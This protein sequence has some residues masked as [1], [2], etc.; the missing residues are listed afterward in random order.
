MSATTAA[1]IGVGTKVKGF[2]AAARIPFLSV[3]ILPYLLGAQMARTWGGVQISAP[4]FWLGLAGVVLI[5]LATYFNGEYYDLVEDEVSTQLGRSKF[6]GGGGSVLDGALA[7]ETPRRAANVVTLLAVG[8]GLLLA[9]VYKTGI[10]TLPMG[11]FGMA[12]GYFYSARPFRWVERGIGEFMIGICYGWLPIAVGYYLQ[13]QQLPALLFWTSLP[14]GFTIFNVIY[15]NEYPDFEGDLKAGKRNLLQ[16]VGRE[17]GI[18]IY[19]AA[20]ALAVLTFAYATT[21]GV[22]SGIWPWYAAV[23]AIQIV[24]VAMLLAGKW[25]VRKM[26]EP[27]C[28]IT[29][30]VNLATT[31]VLIA[32]FWPKG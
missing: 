4:V 29:V 10:W 16:R 12:C 19:I 8:V 28:G 27:I 21:Q 14:V 5:T 20:A 31:A 17:R 15:V 24:P 11:I 18:W 6:A 32:A 25:R 30:V 22:P 9:F 3:S 23:V 2:A 1:P 26:L 7:K 13:T